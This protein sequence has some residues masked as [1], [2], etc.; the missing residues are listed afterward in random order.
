MRLFGAFSMGY[1]DVGADV[2]AALGIVALF[3]AG[4]TPLSFLIASIVYVTTGLVYAELSSTYPVA[5]GAHVF[6]AKGLNDLF[7]FIAGWLLILSYIVDISL[8]AVASA[9]YLSFLIPGIRELRLSAGPLEVPGITLVAIALICL[10]LLIN[11]IGIRESALFTEVLVA[12]DLIVE[13]LLLSLGILN[14]IRNPSSLLEGMREFGSPEAMGGVVYLPGLDLRLQNVLYGTTIAMSSFIGIES[15]AQASEEIKRP[16]RWIPLATKMSIISVLIYV[17]GLSFVSI[18]NV[19]WRTLAENREMSLAVLALSLPLIGRYASII[20]AF[21]GFLVT[22]AS[23]NTGVVGA[24]RVLYSMGKFK[25]MPSYLSSVSRRFRTPIRTILLVGIISMILSFLRELERIA[26]VYTVAALISYLLV[27]YSLMRIRKLETRAFRP[28]R[29]PGDVR[30]LGRELN[31]VAL[32]GVSSTASL[33][34]LVLLMHEVG[35]VVGLVWLA[36]GLII[37]AAYRR[38]AGMGLLGR[39]SAEAIKPPEYRR[40]A[41]VLLRPYE[42]EDV[43]EDIKRG[44]KG[45]YRLHLVTVLDPSGL[46][47]DELIEMKEAV[48]RSLRAMAREL[49][50]G[51]FD[52]DYRVD[53]GD[54]AEVALSLASSDLFDFVIVIVGKGSR[55]LEEAGV[56]R[57]L[58]SRLPGKVMALRR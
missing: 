54:P 33:L 56:A 46:R 38:A 48:G 44:L 55:K 47:A 3:S 20:V 14:I 27:N 8:F 42:S 5:G 4:A 9:G 15:I 39:I 34:A 45:R 35:R 12:V 6:A 57:L 50:E 26:D 43:V 52:A 28:W 10:L 51:G 22:L 29:V 53:F 32:I 31:L 2:Y 40:E 36:A 30:I 25:L 13:T 1:A 58:M 49:E 18:G 21:T 17:L 11:L 19:G 24:S 16:Y 37:Y 7:G 41:L 23:S